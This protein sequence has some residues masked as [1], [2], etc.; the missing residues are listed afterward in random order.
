MASAWPPI[1]PCTRN[2]SLPWLLVL[3]GHDIPFW[4]AFDVLHKHVR[5]DFY[6]GSWLVFAVYAN[7]N[8][9]GGHRNLRIGQIVIKETTLK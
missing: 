4:K 8:H 7:S 6:I 9:K 2:V 3:I 1:R 5:A